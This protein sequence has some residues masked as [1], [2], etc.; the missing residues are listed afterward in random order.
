MVVRLSDIRPKTGKKQ[1]KNAFGIFSVSKQTQLYLIC[2]CESDSDP[3]TCSNLSV[4]Y[5]KAPIRRQDLYNDR[6]KGH[7]DHGNH[8]N[9][10]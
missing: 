8:G 2:M 5:T 10:L 4:K 3:K 7:L 9:I 6:L 1:Q